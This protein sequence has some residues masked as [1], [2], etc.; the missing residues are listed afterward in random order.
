MMMGSHW[1]SRLRTRINRRPKHSRNRT[2]EVLEQRTLLTVNAL[3]NNGTLIVQSDAADAIVLGSSAGVVTLEVNGVLDTSIAPIMANAVESIVITG[4]DADNTIDITNVTAARFSFTNGMGNPVTIDVDAKDGSDTLLGSLD[5]VATLRGGDGNDTITSVAPSDILFGGDG[6]DV[7]TGGAGDDSINAGDGADQVTGNT[8]DD[9][10]MGG[11]GADIVSGGDGLDSILGGDGADVISG[12]AGDDTINGGFGADLINGNGGDDSLLGGIDNDMIF[13]DAGLDFI[14]GGQGDDILSGGLDDDAISGSSGNDILSGD[15]GNDLLHGDLGNDTIDGNEGLDTVFGGGNNDVIDGGADDD[16]LF[17]NS[18]ADTINGGGGADF[19]KGGAGDDLIRSVAAGILINDFVVDPEGD[20]GS[21]TT[22]VFTLALTAAQSGTVTVEFAT[23]D[24][25]AT[26]GSDY[27]AIPNGLAT[28]QPGQITTTVTVEI[29][30]DDA[31]ETAE[32]F[33]LNLSNA[34]GGIAILDAQGLGTINNDDFVSGLGAPIVNV[35][36]E[37]FN[38]VQPPDVNGDIG[39]NFFIQA[40]NSPAGGTQIRIFDK[41]TG[42][43]TDAF[44]LQT[45]APSGSTAVNSAGDPIVLY[46]HLANRWFLAEFSDPSS[47][48]PNDIHIYISRT[49][50]PTSS[51]TDWFYYTFT[52]PSFPDYLKFAVWPDGYYMTSQEGAANP[53]TYVFDRANML[54]GQPA[55]PFQRVTTTGLA[56]FGFQ[57]LTP[58]DVDG[59]APPVGSPAFILRHRDDEAHNVGANDPTQDFIE[60]YEYSAD[61]ATPANST[62]GLSQTIS[63]SEFDSDLNGLF[64]FSAITQPGGALP[65]DPLREVI[66]WRLSY[67]N[68][69]THEVLLGNMVTDV[70]GGDVAGIRWFELRRAPGNTQWT[71]YQEGTHFLPDGDSRWMGAIAMDDAGNI[72]LGYSVS[73]PTTFPSLR[74]TGRRA[75]DPLGQMTQGEFVIFDGTSSQTLGSPQGQVRWGDYFS[76]SVDPVDGSTFWF[77]GQYGTGGAWATQVASFRFSQSGTPGGGTPGGTVISTT[78]LGDTINGGSGLDTIIGAGGDDLLVG[79]FDEDNIFGGNGNDVIFGGAA[80]DTIDGGGGDDTI[81]G[82]GGA[83]L[84]SGSSGNDELIWR[85]ARDSNDSFDGGAGQDLLTVRLDQTANVVTVGQELSTL[86]IT[87]G[88]FSA[89]VASDG[90]QPR[91]EEI[92]VNGSLGDDV[93]TLTDVN[94]IGTA[95]I[96][97]NGGAGDDTISAANALIGNVILFLN[98]DLGADVI[99]GSAG[100][101]SIGGGDD[102]DV[103]NGGNGPDTIRGGLGDDLLAGDDGNDVIL[104]EEDN[105]VINGG[106]GNDLLNGGLGADT[107]D[108][109]DGNDTLLGELGDDILLGDRGNDSIEG[110]SGLDTLNGAAGDDTLDGGANDDVLLGNS[111]DDVLRGA[112]GNDILRGHSGDDTIDGGD[113][114]DSI[115]GLAGNDGI[116]AGD[117]ADYVN[118]GSGDDTVLGGDG[119]D[120]LRGGSGNDVLFGHDGDDTLSGNGGTDTLV[121]GLGAD[122]FDEPTEQDELFML[123]AAVLAS[124]NANV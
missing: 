91:I 67:R 101:D 92:Q 56:G 120:E 37:P 21:T 59:P 116:I 22:A 88:G 11:N 8:G 80:D 102:A 58:A 68:M 76:M 119:A 13:G 118:A 106:N 113:G 25:T 26:A 90:T 29:L 33:F 31:I 5:L 65:L 60:I 95:V 35:P 43:E 28:F 32:T 12:D 3:F 9:T 78:D 97:L 24:G 17:G 114:D 103:I 54:L 122:Q 64:S 112:D 79:D 89:R 105:D 14:D 61:F 100:G 77:T 10:I 44:I 1:L 75:S 82:Q 30:G 20:S 45:L 63:I 46:D 94:N 96:R 121:G 86:V 70:T 85:G 104:G 34:T 124:L 40:T 49:S 39:Q 16:L 19:L 74:Y 109:D 51:P 4:S 108:G 50:T 2:T 98:G 83:D 36:G 7:I 15:E 107:L 115:F 6:D 62:F 47:G 110:G 41:V 53:P 57:A 18:G 42:A 87:E 117:G 93:L 72:A 48:T 73:G 52:T 99:T 81:F 84:I 66:M 23:A 55:R 71:L 111:G 27:T 38:G 69:G 123:S